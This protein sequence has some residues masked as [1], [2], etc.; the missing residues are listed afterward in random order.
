MFIKEKGK[1]MEDFRIS[2]QNGDIWGLPASTVQD[3]IIDYYGED[4]EQ[5]DDR[6][7]LIDWLENNMD[8]EDIKDSLF[9][10]ETCDFEDTFENKVMKALWNGDVK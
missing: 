3:S 1:K 10:V 8:F 7:E 2:L 5:L 9:K 4:C 6:E